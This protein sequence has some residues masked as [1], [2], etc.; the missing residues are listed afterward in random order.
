MKRLQCNEVGG[1]D[2]ANFFK[3]DGSVMHMD[4]PKVWLNMGANLLM[5][6]GKTK[7][8]NLQDLFTNT[9]NLQEVIQQMGNNGA[10]QLQQAFAQNTPGAVEGAEDEDEDDLPDLIETNFDEVAEE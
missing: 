7:D 2:S 5:V 10:Q 9:P 1:C 8:W 6:K 4:N 3:D